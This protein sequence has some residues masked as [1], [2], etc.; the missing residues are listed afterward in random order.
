MKILYVEDNSNDADLARRWL[1]K[2]ASQFVLEVVGT[3]SEAV[4]LLSRPDAPSYDLVLA[5]LRLPDG[6]GL[7]LLTYIRDRGLPLAVV[8]ITGTGDEKTAVTALKAGADDYVSKRDDYLERL[9]LTLENAL[10]RRRAQAARQARTLKALYAERHDTDIDLT[11][12]HLQRYAP[13]IQLDVART[14]AEALQRLP[15]A[16]EASRY[17]VILLDYRLPGLNAL[18]VL[19]ELRQDRAL[20]I[21]VV[22]VTGQGD[23]EVALQALKLGAAGY[24]VKNPGYLHQLPGELENACY[25]AEIIREQAALKQSEERFRS[26]FDHATI[27]MALIALD[28]CFLQVNRSVCEL[29]GYSEQELVGANFKSHTHPDDLDS[30][31]AYMRRLLADEMQSF[32]MEKR[33][34]HKRGHLIWALVSVSLLR[35]GEGRPIYF[36]S[37]IQDITERK[38]AEEALRES[39]AR[40]RNLA[41]NAPVMVWVTE[42]DGACSYLSQSWYEFT[43]QTP[44]TGIGFGWVAALHPD[45]REV[46]EKSFLTANEKREAFRL[47]YRLRRKDGEYRWA[48]DAAR[49]R[50]SSQGEFLGYVGS[51]VDITE[52]KLAELNTQF[53]NQLDFDL[54]QIADADEVIR[55]ATSRLGEYLGVTSCYVIEVN[56]A[57]GSAFVR[58]SWAG[59]RNAGPSIVGEYRISDFVTPE[60]LDEFK[61]GRATVVKD[62]MN[63]P[64]IRDFASKYKSLGVGAFIS[65]PAL[66][67][68]Q[69]EANLTVDHPQARD[70]RPDETQLMRDIAARLW[71]AYKRARAVEALSDSEQRFRQLAENIGAVFF[72]TEGFSPTPPGQILYVSPAYEKIWGRSRE[73]LY[74]DTRSWLEALHPEDKERVLASLRSVGR[75]HFDEEFRIMRPDGEVRWI[76]DRVFPIRDERGEIYRLAGIVEDITERKQF[77]DALRE[78][79]ERYRSVVE[80]QTELICRYLPDTTLTFVNA[81]YCRYF[82]KTQEELIGAKFLELIPEPAREGTLEYIQSLIESPRVEIYEHEVMLPNGGIGWQQWVDHAILDAGGKVVEF[83]AVG[84]D[85]TERKQIEEER[86]EGEERLRLALEAGRMGVWERDTRTNAVKWSRESFTI[87]GLSPFGIAPDYHIWADR[88]HPDDLSVANEKMRKAIEEKGDFRHEY[89]IIWPDGSVRWVEGH[90]KP[91]Y[92]EEGQSLKVSGLIVDI[93]ERKQAE[94]ALRESE[95]RLRHALEAG[96]LGAWEWDPRTNAVKWS[97][98]HYTV[99]GL[100]PFSVEPDYHT[101]ADRVHPDDLPVAEKA[102]SRAIDERGE[103]RH[104]YRVIW[105]DGSV[106]WVEGRGQPV[107]NE[108]GQ[109]LKVSGLI[110]DI[111]ERKQAEDALRQSEARYRAIVEDQTELVC[112]VLPDGR[113]TFVNEAYCRYFGL[114]SEEMIGRTFQPFIHPEDAVK[115]NQLFASITPSNPVGTLEYRVVLPDGGVRWHQWTERGIFD[116]QGRLLEYQC[117]G[118]DITQRKKA[119]ERLVESEAQLRLLT[120]LIP[121]HVWTGFPGNVAD[122]RNQRWLDYTGMTIEEVREKGWMAA[123]HPDDHGSVLNAIREAASQKRIYEVEERLRRADGQYRWFLARA[124]PQLDEEG[125]IIKWYGT[126]TDIEDRKQAEDALRLSEDKFSKAF[127]SSPDAYAIGRQADGMTL[128]VNERWEEIFGYTRGEAVGRTVGELQIYSNPSERASLVSLVKEQGSVRD[129]EADIRRKSGE[130][131]NVLISAEPIMIR[132]EPCLIL[133]ARDITELKRAEEALR[134]NEEALRESYTRIEDLAGRLIAAQE[135]E[136]RH[137]ARELHDDLNQQVAALAIGISRLKRQIPDAT[138]A[139]QEQIARLREKTDWLSERIRQVSHE[140]HSSIL[141]HVGLPAALNSYCAEFSDREGIAVTLDILDGVDAVS[142]EVALCLYRVAQESLRN[143]ARHS[144]ARSAV[145]ALAGVNGAIELR[146]ADQGVGFDPGQAREGRGLGLV[147]MEERV[148]LLNGN[149]VLTTQPGAGTELRAQIPL[150]GEH[151]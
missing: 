58:D 14:G 27:G 45:D 146:V 33:Y 134:R 128:E 60:C 72:I 133:I 11:L 139:I 42:A 59:W 75:A 52:T 81:P 64:R 119:E 80:S 107:Y 136:R 48:L 93:S 28:G 62:V 56:P 73:S 97:K 96:R 87:M 122:F 23:E 148:K 145:V 67:E 46:S 15:Q 88:V 70:W 41:D 89:R 120:E 30:N 132:D 101:W 150:R 105:P 25:R 61:A 43:G 38:Q 144:G 5:D 8:V 143:V 123:L 3:R 121:Q 13:Y 37:Q 39:E 34:I 126:N 90:G 79:E 111:T 129:F 29:F 49:P 26:A 135:E 1:R 127:R 109:C 47:E 147:S 6:D 116:E 66:N 113:Y 50:F 125:K 16:G 141:Q 65:I 19:K 24:L 83:Q 110:V 112:R 69:W 115:V 140:L 57:T 99:M 55:L 20:D 10:R 85:I 137:I 149:L 100:A 12:R 63:D 18:E 51:V 151:E 21:P 117:V 2:H 7:S 78:S 40:F 142:Q 98:D 91:V 77:E 118:R 86:R 103:Y 108:V 9:P 35:D 17:D 130:I 4:D 82:G 84:R 114:K 71:P 68:R 138:P 31:L 36:I 44:E 92:D 124:I 95:E 53:I 54:S 104:E 102:M 131:R 76:H 94:E 74:Q 22:L 32:Q 106:R